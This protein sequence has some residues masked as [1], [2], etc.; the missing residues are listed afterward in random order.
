MDKENLVAIE[1]LLM[2]GIGYY[3]DVTNAR[4]IDEAEQED[5]Q[6]I[7]HHGNIVV[8][9]VITRFDGIIRSVI[10]QNKRQSREYI[11]QCI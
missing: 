7:R 6:T 8:T 9:M 11:K 3:G 2:V 4:V 10:K 1:M 5:A